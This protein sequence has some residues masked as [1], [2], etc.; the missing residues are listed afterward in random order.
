MTRT[1]T[2]EDSSA[3]YVEFS[4]EKGL[5][6]VGLFTRRKEPELAQKSNDAMKKA[7][8][9]TVL[10]D[11]YFEELGFILVSKDFLRKIFARIENVQY[12][13]QDSKELDLI[14]ANEYI[15]YFYYESNSHSLIQFLDR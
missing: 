14:A 13:I 8:V 5:R 3:I 15:P 12:L 7:S 11:K 9:I 1:H 2:N 10:C 6:P 4:D